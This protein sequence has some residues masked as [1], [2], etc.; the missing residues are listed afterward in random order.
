MTKEVTR[1][2]LDV[3]D[4]RDRQTIEVL[5]RARNEVGEGLSFNVKSYENTHLLGRLLV[6]LGQQSSEDINDLFKIGTC[7][8]GY[9]DILS[10]PIEAYRK[11]DYFIG[12]ARRGLTI[13][14]Q[15]LQEYPNGLDIAQ[16]THLSL[17][18]NQVYDRVI[19]H[20]AIITA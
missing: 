2:K 12:D 20:C 17:Y 14:G 19:D 8:L 15:R 16:K 10:E 5:L 6:G 13:I 11:L 1:K 7:S 18:L 9:L 3:F 4:P